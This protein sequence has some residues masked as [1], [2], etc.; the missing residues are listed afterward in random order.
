MQAAGREVDI[1]STFLVPDL[2]I[3]CAIGIDLRRHANATRDCGIL[4]VC[5]GG[6][7]HRCV[8]ALEWMNYLA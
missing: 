6:R 1:A 5:E 4:S 7:G 3:F 2:G 8:P